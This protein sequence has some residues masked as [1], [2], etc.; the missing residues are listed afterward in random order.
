[1]KGTIP[2]CAGST[3]SSSRSAACVRDHPRVRGEHRQAAPYS[4]ELAGPSPRARG[5]RRS[6]TQE[7]HAIGT[8]P[9]C[10]G[11]TPSPPLTRRPG[12][13]HPRVRGEHRWAGSSHTAVQGP[14]PRARGARPGGTRRRSSWGTIPACAGSTTAR[15]RRGCGAGDHPRVRGEHR[16]IAGKVL[17]AQGP[18]PRARGALLAGTRG[19]LWDGTIPACAGSTLTAGAAR[20]GQRDHP[21]VRG[22]HFSTRL[23]LNFSSGPSP[24]ARGALVGALPETTAAGTIPACAGSTQQQCGR[25]S[26]RGDHPRVR[27]EHTH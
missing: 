9:A 12:W 3:N 27:G 8:I 26:R 19:D 23:S 13:D 5:A 1:M 17:A 6:A 22:E 15:S 16:A 11:S 10:A 18:S 24:R 25:P 20:T 7:E 4:I 21:R 14:S 2:A